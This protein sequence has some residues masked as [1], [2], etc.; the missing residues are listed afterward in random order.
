M[1]SQYQE[2]GTQNI[3]ELFKERTKYAD[4]KVTVKGY[5]ETQLGT[6]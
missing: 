4:T 3:A 2:K 1:H 5:Y 6:Y